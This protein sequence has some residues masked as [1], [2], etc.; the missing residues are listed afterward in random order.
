VV[1]DAEVDVR[2]ELAVEIAERLGDLEVAQVA[3]QAIVPAA[4]AQVGTPETRQA[5]C[6]L[7]Q[8]TDLLEQRDRAL[9]VGQASPV[10][11][12]VVADHRAHHREQAGGDQLRLAIGGLEIDR[13]DHRESAFEQLDRRLILAAMVRGG[14]ELVVQPGTIQGG[15]H[16]DQ[17]TLEAGG[18]R[19][20]IELEQRVAA[21][22]DQ[23]GVATIRQL[24]GA[25]EG[26]VR[27]A[28]RRE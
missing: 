11:A 19:S 2:G 5:A 22:L 3:A 25:S 21:Q 14:S 12:D 9:G 16:R 6:E 18:R 17:R 23:H 28:I 26:E 7:E 13:L 8:V 24:L 15:R 20:G 10:I 27:F 1:V 4:R